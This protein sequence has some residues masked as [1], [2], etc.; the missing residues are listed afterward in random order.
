MMHIEDGEEPPET[1]IPPDFNPAWGLYKRAF[2]VLTYDRPPALGAVAYIPTLVITGYAKETDGVVDKE[3]LR[4]Y[5]RM[6]RAIDVE[7]VN[8]AMDLKPKKNSGK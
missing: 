6:V 4:F 2:D 8:A 3:D 7:W 5:R 1:C